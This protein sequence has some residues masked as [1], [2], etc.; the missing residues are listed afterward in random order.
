[1]CIKV[2]EKT[3]SIRYAE[4]Q[5]EDVHRL[6]VAMPDWDSKS[7]KSVNIADIQANDHPM[8]Y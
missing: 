8:E 2:L 1:M 5:N 7:I 4:K 3:V 6:P